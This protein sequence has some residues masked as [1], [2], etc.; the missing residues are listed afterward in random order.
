[1]EV[2]GRLHASPP[3]TP[4]EEHQYQ[5]NMWL[6]GPQSRSKC[7]GNEESL[8]LSPRIEPLPIQLVA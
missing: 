4:E 7:F 6:G 1:M 3:L 5:M 2:S 8:F